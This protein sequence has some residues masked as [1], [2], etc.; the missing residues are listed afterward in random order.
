MLIGVLKIEELCFVPEEDDVGTN[1]PKFHSKPLKYRFINLLYDFG[2]D[3]KQS[4]ID[5]QDIMI[6][7]AKLCTTKQAQILYEVITKD[8][9]KKVY[10][11]CSNT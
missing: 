2:M 10:R 3:K 9:K 7:I 5:S 6:K 4:I 11:T 8:D 1:E